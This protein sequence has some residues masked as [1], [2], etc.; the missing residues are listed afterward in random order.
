M[1]GGIAVALAS[2]LAWDQGG[3]LANASR[4]TEVAGATYSLAS[5]FEQLRTRMR[6]PSAARTVDTVPPPGDV[7]IAPPPAAF[8]EPPPAPR[9][10]P[11]QLRRGR[12]DGV[13][14]A[15]G[16]WAV[17]IGI[18]D[19]PGTRYDLKSAV[20]D[21]VEVN[22]AL[23]AL[24]VPGDR[25]LLIRDRQATAG[26]IRTAVDW[27]VA[28][29]GPDATAVFFYAGHVRKLG[30]GSEAIVGSDG[31]VLTDVEFARLLEGL[32]ASKT[33]IGLAACYSGGFTEVL[34]PGRVLTAAAS[35][36]ALAYENEAF[37][38]SYLVEY[39]VRR[40]IMQGGL[41]T[42]EGAFGAAQANLRRDYPNRVPVQFDSLSGE[43]DLKVPPPPSSAKAAR[44]AS[45]GGA[46][47]GTGGTPDGSG[48]TTSTEG[49]PPPPR[50]DDGCAALTIG[51]VR[52][53]NS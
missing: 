40:A 17:L 9:P 3:M 14:P 39:M 30:Q 15:G 46:T 5:G 33:W 24:G 31:G 38:R 53:S 26:T 43:L 49:G 7:V 45:S 13:A 19:Y 48:G 6:I 44:P 28:H 41:T 4:P 52:C 50:P 36:D 21:V 34:R 51:M 32:K 1:V 25:R 11:A 37:G 10:P 20:A 2:L 47:G 8:A 22:D 16:T 27:L 18:N 29:A 42:V 35:A 23:G 12:F